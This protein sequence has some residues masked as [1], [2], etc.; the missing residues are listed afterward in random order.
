MNKI[1]ATAIAAAVGLSVS[2]GAVAL[3]S[4]GGQDPPASEQAPVGTLSVRDAQLDAL[5]A[6]LDRKLRAAPKPPDPIT[7]IVPSAPAAGASAAR[8]VD[9]DRYEDRDGGGREHEDDEDD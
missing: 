8:H 6:E 5:E 3:S 7:T 2:L 1:H 9:D 4:S